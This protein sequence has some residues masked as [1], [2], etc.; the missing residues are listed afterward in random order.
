MVYKSKTNDHRP[1]G[2]SCVPHN[3]L[4]PVILVGL[5]TSQFQSEA[6]IRNLKKRILAI[7]G[8]QLSEA[9]EGY[10]Q[11]FEMETFFWWF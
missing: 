6:E 11:G 9:V 10:A 3:V 5:L 2:P 1:L 7:P 4:I 8:T